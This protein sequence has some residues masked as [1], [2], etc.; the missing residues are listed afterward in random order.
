[1]YIMSGCYFISNNEYIKERY[2]VQRRECTE[3]ERMKLAKLQQDPTQTPV[4]SRV[5]GKPKEIISQLDYNEDGEQVRNQESY[6]TYIYS[7]PYPSVEQQIQICAM[8]SRQFHEGNR[9]NLERR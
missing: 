5:G 7:G 1:M 8:L 2:S 3:L 4:I 6:N 9:P